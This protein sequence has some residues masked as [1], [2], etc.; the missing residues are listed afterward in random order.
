MS[1]QDISGRRKSEGVKAPREMFRGWS[2]A[3]KTGKRALWLQGGE[4]GGNDRAGRNGSLEL[5]GELFE[6]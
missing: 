1:E 2:D 3:L 5:N 6:C 4:G